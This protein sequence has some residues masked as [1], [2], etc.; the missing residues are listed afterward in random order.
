MEMEIVEHPV[1]QARTRLGEIVNDVA[2]RKKRHLIRRRSELAAL[3]APIEDFRRIET[4]LTKARG[5]G[6]EKGSVQKTESIS[7][8]RE[9]RDRLPDMLDKITL[10]SK[11]YLIERRGVP[12]AAMLPIEDLKDLDPAAW[13]DLV[14]TTSASKGT[15]WAGSTV[16]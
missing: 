9:S 4:S 14:R 6:A 3:I 2:V 7:S 10:E 8:I 15:V 12:L 11:R 1:V 16:V 5:S 13:S